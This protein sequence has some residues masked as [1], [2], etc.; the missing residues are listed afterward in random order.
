MKTDEVLNEPQRRTRRRWSLKEKQAL[1]ERWK[2]S[3]KSRAEFCR[4]EELSYGNFLSWEKRMDAMSGSGFVEV[5]AGKLE[6]FRDEWA[7]EVVVPNGWRIR[8][9]ES[10]GGGSR[11]SALK[12][13][14]EMVARC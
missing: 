12:E 13:V 11:M 3:G 6:L 10:S 7:V 5:A 14:L 4:E 8:L 2:Q 1:V 9:A